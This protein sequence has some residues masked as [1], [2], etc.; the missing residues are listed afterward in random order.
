MYSID[1]LERHYIYF[2]DTFVKNGKGYNVSSGGHNGSPWAGKTEEELEEWKVKYGTPIVGV[3]ID[4]ILSYKYIEEA[5]K[6]GF[7]PKGISTTC[8]YPS[9]S[10]VWH[11]FGASCA[12][13]QGRKP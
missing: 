8:T 9:S 3:G 4:S 10:F 1:M 13:L 11:C 5:K 12:F 7:N 2:F 6:D